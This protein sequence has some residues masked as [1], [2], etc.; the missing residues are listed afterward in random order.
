MNPSGEEDLGHSFILIN[1]TMTE[2]V[3]TLD[4][5]DVWDSVSLPAN[6]SATGHVTAQLTLCM[7]A[8]EAQDMEVHAARPASAPP[9]PELT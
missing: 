7:L 1:A 8:F 3:T 4:S 5:A 9:E 6:D 2:D